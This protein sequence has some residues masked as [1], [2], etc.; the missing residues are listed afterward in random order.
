VMSRE[1]SGP[2]CPVSLWNGDSLGLVLVGGTVVLR[3][4]CVVGL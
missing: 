4:T 3:G 1:S 2:S